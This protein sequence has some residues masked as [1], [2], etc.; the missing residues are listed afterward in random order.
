[1]INLAVTHQ[2]SKETCEISLLYGILHPVTFELVF[3]RPTN[4]EKLAGGKR[5]DSSSQ[6]PT[7]LIESP[8]HHSHHTRSFIQPGDVVSLYFVQ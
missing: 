1:M 5:V 2:S 7:S 4:S 3:R 6:V 8:L